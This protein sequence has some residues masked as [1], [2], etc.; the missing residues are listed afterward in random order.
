MYIWPIP[1]MQKYFPK[2]L[3]CFHGGCINSAQEGQAFFTF[4]VVFPPSP[5]GPSHFIG[6]AGEEA[7][8][9]FMHVDRL[10][11]TGCCGVVCWLHH[12][13][14]WPLVPPDLV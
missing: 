11:A 7:G 10:V 13:W 14:L 5:L 1:C 2:A 6:Q 4:S 12:H 8:E 9:G 3:N